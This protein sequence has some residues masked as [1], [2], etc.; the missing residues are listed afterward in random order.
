M[1]SKTN[2][3]VMQ[4]VDKI[5][6]A[7]EKLETMVFEKYHEAEKEFSFT[8]H[9]QEMNFGIT[10]DVQISIESRQRDK[11]FETIVGL[12]LDGYNTKKWNREYMTV[13]NQ[14]YQKIISNTS[15]MDN[16]VIPAIM[17]WVNER[18]GKSDIYDLRT[19]VQFH[20]S[21]SGKT[22]GRRYQYTD[23]N[24]KYIEQL[25]SY[26]EKSIQDKSYCHFTS[27]MN[28]NWKYI[29]A[30]FLADRILLKDIILFLES[31]IDCHSSL[32]EGV[33]I[34]LIK[35]R[36]DLTTNELDALT[37]FIFNSK[38]T[39]KV[40]K[41]F[42]KPAILCAV[43]NGYVPQIPIATTK[44]ELMNEVENGFLKLEEKIQAL[45]F[46]STVIDKNCL[47]G[48]RGIELV[49][50]NGRKSCLK[51]NW[52]GIWTY[53]ETTEIELDKDLSFLYERA[54][55]TQELTDE[56]SR[57]L[58]YRIKETKDQH[59][60]YPFID[61]EFRYVYRGWIGFNSQSR[62]NDQIISWQN[63]LNDYLSE[64]KE[65]PL[66]MNIDAV[67]VLFETMVKYHND[68]TLKYLAGL[69]KLQKK[70][71][72]KF[73]YSC[74]AK[75]LAMMFERF[76]DYLL[77]DYDDQSLTLL[78]DIAWTYL[79]WNRNVKKKPPL[80]ILKRLYS[81]HNSKA[82]EL[83][84][85]YKMW[86]DEDYWY[87]YDPENLLTTKPN[88][89]FIK[90]PVIKAKLRDNHIAIWLTE[91]S[92]LAYSQALTYLHW[93]MPKATASAKE[94]GETCHVAIKFIDEPIFPQIKLQGY[95]G[96]E[97]CDLEIE[98]L[99]GIPKTPELALMHKA[100]S[101]PELW[102]QIRKYIRR[103]LKL[104]SRTEYDDE[105]MTL[106][107]TPAVVAFVLADKSHL[108]LLNDYV[109]YCD[110]E[111]EEVQLALIPAIQ[112][113]YGLNNATMKAILALSSSAQNGQEML[114]EFPDII[115]YI[116][117]KT[118]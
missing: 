31:V 17:K 7:L 25:L 15:V 33:Y 81:I 117:K 68:Q 107:A 37:W 109:S 9:D 14:D 18:I 12:G 73:E 47:Y 38:F 71:E 29:L 87:R 111:H 72:K 114:Q 56:V 103:L 58:S 69:K 4:L 106:H 113:I 77:E 40:E 86:Q 98:S 94:L 49:C 91:E 92:E 67:A 59:C 28:H 45:D 93:A 78:A 70:N 110:D 44:E 26:F 63:E 50:E 61:F 30:L 19:Y 104:E 55:W 24:L 116:E 82:V 1:E 46:K 62:D 53:E 48:L 6:N 42:K 96:A 43:K 95:Y 35:N 80:K 108:K 89:D 118:K 20:L 102:P 97:G 66:D 84:A 27:Q 90:E 76:C 83:L 34:D 79:K 23:C 101:Y 8:K 3:E 74:Y 54:E 99:L 88:K 52:N 115:E 2:S 64:L 32:D 57:I 85:D 21:D 11:Q 16:E 13:S 10:D 36:E 41:A 51:V 100:A 112:R 5:T 65:L 39:G 22:I 105:Y 60:Y 75:G